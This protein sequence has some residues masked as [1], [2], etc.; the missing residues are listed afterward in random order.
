V[1]PKRVYKQVSFWL[2]CVI[3]TAII[4]FVA[5]AYF[6]ATLYDVE[7][8]IDTSIDH[9]SVIFESVDDDYGDY[10]KLYSNETFKISYGYEESNGHFHISN[11]TIY[12]K[13]SLIYEGNELPRIVLSQDNGYIIGFPIKNDA[14]DTTRYLFLRDEKEF[15][16]N[17]LLK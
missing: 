6:M 9:G 1:S 4:W 15:V 16:R 5:F 13:Y 8:Y 12:L 10:L 14:I 2:T 11:D 17:E 3:S 7:D